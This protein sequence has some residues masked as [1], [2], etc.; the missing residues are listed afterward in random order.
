MF[1]N[2][3]VGW[4]ARVSRWTPSSVPG[5]PQITRQN[6]EEKALLQGEGQ[7]AAW[8]LSLQKAEVRGNAG[9][10]VSI[11][12]RSVDKRSGRTPL[13]IEEGICVDDEDKET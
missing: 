7:A 5:L 3:T 11:V 9:K 12:V 2:E 1:S 10:V 6:Q 8:R 4:S 13:R